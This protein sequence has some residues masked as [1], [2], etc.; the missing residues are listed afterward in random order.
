MGTP[1]LAFSPMKALLVV[2]ATLSF[3]ASA[4]PEAS[5]RLWSPT[6]T[7]GSSIPEKNVYN[8][9]GCSGANVSPELRWEGVPAGTKALGLTMYDPDAPT[10]SGWWHWIVYNLPPDTAKLPAGAGDPKAPKLP[11]GAAQGKTD[12]AVPGYG[13]PCPPKGDKAHRYVFT[14]FAL[15]DKVEASA[16]T[17][18]AAIGY[19]LHAKAIGRATFTASYGR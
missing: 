13:G 1:R 8:S 2:L 6:I 12:F 14:L 7:A 19:Q 9:F 16:D 10:G 18:P 5:F 11:A 15:K 4:K 3:T 17:M